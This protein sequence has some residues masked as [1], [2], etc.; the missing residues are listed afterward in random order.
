M[1]RG[2]NRR[3]KKRSGNGHARGKKRYDTLN[4]KRYGTDTETLRHGHGN[5]TVRTRKRYGTDTMTNSGPLLY[6]SRS[7]GFVPLP[8]K[9]LRYRLMSPLPTVFVFGLPTAPSTLRTVT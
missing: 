8:I 5:A 7:Y 2:S 9:G 4:R 6:Y 1:G 3:M